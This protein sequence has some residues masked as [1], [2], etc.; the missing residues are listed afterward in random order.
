M[1]S[2]LCVSR[3]LANRA[4]TY[5]YIAETRRAMCRQSGVSEAAGDWDVGSVARRRAPPGRPLGRTPMPLQRQ[6]SRRSLAA[7]DCPRASSALIESCETGSPRVT[8]IVR[9]NAAC[10]EWC[11]F[12]SMSPTWP[13]LPH[14]C[15]HLQRANRTIRPACKQGN[16][17][18]RVSISRVRPAQSEGG[19]NEALGET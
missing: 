5:E 3:R 8:R 14:A 19:K 16:E 12:P 2:L 13:T 1:G 7:L 11:V 9:E 15:P 6:R 10:S 17:G 4:G 18:R